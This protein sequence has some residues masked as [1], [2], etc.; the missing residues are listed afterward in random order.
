MKRIAALLIAL[1][2]LLSAAPALGCS[3]P[4]DPGMGDC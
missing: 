2:L 4:Y 1:S 3:V